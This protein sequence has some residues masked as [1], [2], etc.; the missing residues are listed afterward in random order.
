MYH[1]ARLYP[2][3]WGM[4]K[5]PRRALSRKG[6]GSPLPAGVRPAPRVRERSRRRNMKKILRERASARARAWE[7]VA[8]LCF[9]ELYFVVFRTMA[10]LWHVT[11]L[12]RKTR[13]WLQLPLLPLRILL[14][15]RSL[16]LAFTFTS[17]PVFHQRER[18]G[19]VKIA[20][21]KRKQYFL[22]V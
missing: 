15:Y 2:A 12:R 13:K 6:L 19:K 7:G 20:N 21:R 4:E 14:S 11:T 16:E 22:S 8:F 1:P 5:T 18:K 10:A 3:L 17:D 9:K